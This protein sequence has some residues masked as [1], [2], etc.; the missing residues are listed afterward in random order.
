MSSADLQIGR[1]ALARGAWL[2]ARDAFNASLRAGDT[3]EA[4]EGLGTAAWWLD[5]ADVVFD[6]RERAYRLYLGREDPVG[7]ARVAVWLAWD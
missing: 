5:L 2:E 4:L 7:A 6:A 3:P 1:D